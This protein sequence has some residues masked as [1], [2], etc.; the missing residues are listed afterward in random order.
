MPGSGAITPADIRDIFSGFV[1]FVT[2]IFTGDMTGAVAGLSRLWDGLTGYYRT[3]WAGIGRI[4]RAA[5][6]GVIKPVTDALGITD[7]IVDAWNAARDT[8][9]V[10]LDAI[11]AVF[12]RVWT[13]FIRPAID[14][15]FS[16]EGVGAV[17]EG[18]KSAIGVVLD[19]LGAKFAAI[20]AVIS[21]VIDGLKW[22]K[23]KG[24]EALASIGLGS[25]DRALGASEIAAVAANSGIHPTPRVPTVSAPHQGAIDALF[26]EPTPRAQGGSFAPGLLL[27]GERGPELRYESRGGFIAHHNALCGL[28]DLS[29]R[30]QALAGLIMGAGAGPELAGQMAPAM[31]PV[32][33]A[34]G[35]RQINHQPHYNIV[36]NG[37]GL[38]AA[39][40]RAAVKAELNAA[41]RRARA[42]L[43]GLLHD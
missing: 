17:W 30:A 21:P 13:G 28:V 15:L 33:A 36:I 19:W 5:W 9:S 35:A 1:Q 25:D 10:V 3:L 11:G 27:V 12:D 37:S 20:W 4:F 16:I 31:A 7:Y 14:G 22:V 29:Q 2:G 6:T 43:R 38:D 23:D 26:G 32:A 8:L 42:D 24:A 34:T 39:Q 18:I 40:L 41:A